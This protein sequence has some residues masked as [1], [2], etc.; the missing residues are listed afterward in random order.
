MVYHGR[1]LGLIGI[2]HELKRYGEEGRTT[3]EEGQ[4]GK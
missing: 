4:R 3:A 2:L 1:V